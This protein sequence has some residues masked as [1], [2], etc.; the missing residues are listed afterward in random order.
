MVLNFKLFDSLAQNFIH[1]SHMNQFII[2]FIHF[3]WLGLSIH[4]RVGTRRYFICFRCLLLMH[5]LC[6]VLTVHYSSV[7]DVFAMFCVANGDLVLGL[8]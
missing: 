5:D 3:D 1:F 8:L 7:S 2:N 6:L 4:I